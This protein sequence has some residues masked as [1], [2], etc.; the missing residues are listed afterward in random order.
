MSGRVRS[1]PGTGRRHRRRFLPARA[2]SGADGAVVR[3]VALRSASP[4]FSACSKE[5]TTAYYRFFRILLNFS[6]KK[7]RAS[8]AMTYW[9]P[10][11]SALLCLLP[12]GMGPPAAAQ[13]ALPPLQLPEATRPL[14]P[15]PDLR[16]EPL[17][18]VVD[19]RPQS[20][21]HPLHALPPTR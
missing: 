20:R 4:S 13:I 5:E 21:L 17:I 6:G 16:A 18:S 15:P 2:R 9:K 14:P 3:P 8:H 10:L 1:P 11:L 7:T 12:A 19:R